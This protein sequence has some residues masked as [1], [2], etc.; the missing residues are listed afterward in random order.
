MRANAPNRPV[1]RILLVEDE[2][3]IRNLL[4][5]VLTTQ[6]YELLVASNG[7]EAVSL[8]DDTLAGID[9][10]ISDLIMPGAN[11]ADVAAQ[12][13]ARIPRLGVV[14]MSGSSEHPVL[15]RVLASGERFIG[16]PFSLTQFSTVVDEA[17]SL[18]RES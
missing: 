10:L 4:T 8:D 13:R 1:A 12:L 17:L 6:G 9:L 14:F 3:S 16:K 7:T 15:K 11:G 2:S 18:V 5:R